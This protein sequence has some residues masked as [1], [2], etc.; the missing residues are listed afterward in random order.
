MTAASLDDTSIM[1]I[2]VYENQ[3][4]GNINLTV[5]GSILRGKQGEVFNNAEGFEVSVSYPF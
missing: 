2:P 1:L 4:P 3:L 5:R